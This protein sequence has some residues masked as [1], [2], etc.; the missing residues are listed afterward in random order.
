MLK[1]GWGRNVFW[2]WFFHR[3][4]AF[5]STFFLSMS[6]LSILLISHPFKMCGTWVIFLP[7]NAPLV[8]SIKRKDIKF[9]GL[10]A[11][12]LSPSTEEVETDRFLNWDWP[13]LYS[14]FQAS[15]KYTVR[16]CIK[17]RQ[18]SS[19]KYENSTWTLSQTGEIYLQLKTLWIKMY[20]IGV[21]RFFWEV[22]ILE[23]Y[24]SL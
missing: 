1:L 16:P 10:L 22:R 19:C 7:G 18:K 11:Y 9:S 4:L 6:Y 15:Q 2:M 21:S 20:A 23:L 13:V 5:V 17:N 3:M 12:I 8:S 14:K 24:A